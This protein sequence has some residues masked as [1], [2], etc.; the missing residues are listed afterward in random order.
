MANTSFDPLRSDHFQSAGLNS[1]LV[2]MQPATTSDSPSQRSL[3]LH[4]DVLLQFNQ[5]TE[6][7][8]TDVRS[9]RKRRE[10][11]PSISPK[12]TV[13]PGTSALL[14]PEFAP[15]PL[16]LD[17]KDEELLGRFQF[18]AEMEADYRTLPSAKRVT[19][20]GYIQSRISLK[21]LLTKKW[22]PTYWITYGHNILIFFK[23]KATF[24]EWLYNPYLSKEKR[25]TLIKLG[26]DFKRDRNLQNLRGYQATRIRTKYYKRGGMM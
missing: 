19:H 26:I 21:S 15:P 23:S 17:P 8:S 20:S 9:T 18:M 13:K 4:E 22:K 16:P 1:Q 6:L 2:P 5:Q 7:K 12:T 11:S 10:L 25:M 14:N 24:E 3:P